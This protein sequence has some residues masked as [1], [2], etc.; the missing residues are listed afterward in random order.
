MIQKQVRSD[1]TEQ[2]IH[3]LPVV[4]KI[5]SVEIRIYEPDTVQWRP[6]RA[7]FDKSARSGRIP[8]ALHPLPIALE[9]IRPRIVKLAQIRGWHILRYGMFAVELVV[10]ETPAVQHV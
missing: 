10:V 3:P 4:V 5:V 8:N 6:R 2:G 1:G 9:K 7:G